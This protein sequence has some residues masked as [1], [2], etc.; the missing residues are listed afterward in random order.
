MSKKYFKYSLYSPMLENVGLNV[1]NCGY[2]QCIGGHSWGPAVRDYYLIHLVLSG[3]GTYTVDGQS[4][5]L[6]KGNAF[7]IR[8]Q[9]LVSYCADHNDPWQYCWIGFNGADA[10]RLV[11]LSAFEE[12]LPVIVVDKNALPKLQQAFLSVY[13][14]FGTNAEQETMTVSKLYEAFS[15]MIKYAPKKK[16]DSPSGRLYIKNAI[17][18]I[19]RNFSN[20]IDVTDIANH[21]GLSRSHLYRVFIKHLSLSPNEYLTQYRVNQACILLRTSGLS[22]GEIAGSVGFD[23]QLYFSRVFKKTKGVPPSHYLKEISDAK[24]VGDSIE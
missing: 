3:K 10:L 18:F 15:L 19:Q 17:K 1:Y 6:E 4:Y 2:Q 7:I 21:V 12:D 14:N 9:S 20:S 23:D 16:S 11:D 5:E 13:S 22:I 8:P 24:N